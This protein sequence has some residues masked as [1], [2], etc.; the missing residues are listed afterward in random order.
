MYQL[1]SYILVHYNLIRTLDNMYVIS[2]L[3]IY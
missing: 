2:D 1:K 3:F